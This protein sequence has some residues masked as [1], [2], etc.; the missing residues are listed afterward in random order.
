MGNKN[1]QMVLDRAIDIQQQLPG[2]N[3]MHYELEDTKKFEDMVHDK[4]QELQIE[5]EEADIP[6]EKEILVSQIGT[7][8]CVL[9]HLYRLNVSNDDKIQ[10]IEITAEI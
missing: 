6:R 8:E 2:V 10:A 1:Y 9:G 4:I 7:L 3:G 5:L